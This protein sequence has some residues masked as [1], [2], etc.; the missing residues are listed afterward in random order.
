VAAIFRL[1]APLSKCAGDWGH[2][3]RGLDLFSRWQFS[4]TGFA[5]LAREAKTPGI[6]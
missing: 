6:Y 2:Q 1:I 5:A 3:R 4:G